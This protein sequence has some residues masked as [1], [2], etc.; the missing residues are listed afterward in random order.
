M[1]LYT[2]EYEAPGGSAHGHETFRAADAAGAVAE[3][4]RRFPG[5]DIRELRRVHVAEDPR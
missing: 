5:F 2:I 3:F 1:N 4:G